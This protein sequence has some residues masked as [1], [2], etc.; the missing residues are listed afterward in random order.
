MDELYLDNI[1]EYVIDH[2]KIVSDCFTRPLSAFVPLTRASKF[3]AAELPAQ[4][5]LT[6]LFCLF[7]MYIILK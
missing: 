6:L 2:N 5:C 1:D 7:E 3:V 4:S